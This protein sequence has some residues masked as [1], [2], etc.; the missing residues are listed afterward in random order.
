MIPSIYAMTQ[1]SFQKDFPD[2][3]KYRF[4]QI[5]KWRSTGALSFDDY[6]NLDKNTIKVLQD[7]SAVFSSEVAEERGDENSSK[8]LIRLNDGQFI[9]SVYMTDSG[10]LHTVCLSSQVGCACNC[11]FCATGALGFNRNLHDYE[12]I[13]QYYH[14]KR[15][16]KKIDKIVFMGMGEPMLNL[17]SVISAVKYFK[18]NEKISARK[19]TIS[20]V[21]IKEGIKKLA[22]ARLG[23]KLTLSLV[24]ANQNEREKI[25]PMAKSN[26]LDDLKKALLYFQSRD[27]RRITL[28]YCMLKGLNT[29]KSNSKELASFSQG[30]VSHINLIPWNEISTL[31]FKTPER[32]EITKFTH[33]LDCEHLKYS[34]R[35]SKGTKIDAAC[36]QLAGKK[37]YN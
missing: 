22:D 16:Y 21:G 10:D 31:N 25:M 4:A 19:I 36:G 28:A 11:A 7:T 23:V 13:E 12:I 6:K 33:F 8:I 35:Y 30:I 9:E 1:E 20:T 5:E 37:K 34:I 26:K 2:I 18:S 24:L 27:N 14:L 32:E 3:P 15:L 29:S 17:D